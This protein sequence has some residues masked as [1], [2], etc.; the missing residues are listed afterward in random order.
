MVN[1]SLL[2]IMELEDVNL[3]MLRLQKICEVAT[4]EID[5]EFIIESDIDLTWTPSAIQKAYK[6][7]T[8]EKRGSDYELYHKSYSDSVVFAKNGKPQKKRLQIQERLTRE[9]AL[10][11]Q[12]TL[13]P[14]AVAVAIKAEHH[15]MCTR[16]VNKP[17]TKMLTS[18]FIGE[19]E[20]NLEFRRSFLEMD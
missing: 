11:I 12:E 16:G 3:D 4:G 13:N 15:C 14:K 10:A 17:G 6:K 20:K 18:S 19:S 9:I 1:C 5:Q 8:T 2:P 7:Y